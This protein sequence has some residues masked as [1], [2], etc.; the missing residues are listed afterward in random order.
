MNWERRLRTGKD[1][2]MQKHTVDDKELTAEIEENMRSRI[3]NDEA[4]EDEDENCER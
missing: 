4:D 2:E 1:E 3:S